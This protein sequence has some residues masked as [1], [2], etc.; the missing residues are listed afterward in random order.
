MDKTAYKRI[1]ICIVNETYF[2][3]RKEYS[4]ISLIHVKNYYSFCLN[5]FVY[6]KNNRSI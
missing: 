6:N 1:S 5:E 3:C 4:I 2:L